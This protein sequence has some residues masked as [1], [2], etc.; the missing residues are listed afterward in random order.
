MLCLGVDTVS[1][2]PSVALVEG[3]SKKTL[4]CQDLPAGRGQSAALLSAVE[5]LLKETGHRY[6]D[7]AKLMVMTG[8][9]SFTGIR[10]GISFLKGVALSLE[11]QLIGAN[12]FEVIES[13]QTIDKKDNYLIALEAGRDEKFFHFVKDGRLQGAPLNVDIETLIKE[14]SAEL[15]LCHFVISDFTPDTTAMSPPWRRLTG[16]SAEDLIY[17]LLPDAQDA[18]SL[19]IPSP[20]YI[21]SADTT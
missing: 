20:Y 19:E 3:E 2:K 18:L 1:A 15:A 10:I 6:Q 7:L 21:R 13:T 16:N 5:T 12:H 17:S 9:G 14:H 11:I 4:A 8:P